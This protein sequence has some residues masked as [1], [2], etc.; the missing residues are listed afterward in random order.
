MPG[1]SRLPLITL[2][3]ASILGIAA[4]LS[5]F[6]SQP[7]RSSGTAMA[8]SGDALWMLILLS[9]LGLATVIANMQSGQ[10][11]SKTL[12]ILGALAAVGSVLRFVPGPAGFSAIFFLPILS[13]YVFGVQFGF[14]AGLTTLLASALLTG[15]VGPWLP[16]QMFASG[17]VGAAAGLMPQPRQGSRWEIGGLAV[18][19][20]LLGL[21]YGLV[22]N[23]WFWPFVFRPDQAAQYWQPG[24][25]FGET[26]KRYALFYM[27][28]SFIWDLWRGI[29]NA[30]LIL[31]FGAPV[32]RLLRRYKRR[33]SFAVK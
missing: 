31:L 8:H 22:M 20:L 6:W 27:T 18:L 10:M 16:Y 29:G 1:K 30:T 19:G 15:G 23:L 33:F 32:L 14:L 17:W 26:V 25:G 4:F 13:G 11:S 21:A 5:P 12:A 9:L 2:V 28:T 7:R 3:L 24:V